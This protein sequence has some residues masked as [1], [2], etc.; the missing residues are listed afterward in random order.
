MIV[1]RRWQRLCQ[2]Y[3]PMRPRGSIWRQ[4]RKRKP[5]DLSQG[6]K[7]HV[8]ATILSACDVFEVVAPYLRQRDICFKAPKSLEELHTLNAGSYGFSQV[9]KFITVYPRSTQEA[10]ELAHELDHRTRNQ[11]APEVP[12]DKPLR[13]GSCVYYRYGS[14]ATRLTI[15]IRNRRQDAIVGKNGKVVVD[16]RKPGAAVPSWLSD[17]FDSSRKKIRLRRLSPLETTFGEYESLVQRGKGGVYRAVNLASRRLCIIK[18]GRRNGE[19]DWEGYDGYHLMEREARFLRAVSPR[20][21][22]VP[23][24]LASFTAD[25]SFHLVTKEI[26]G[27]SLGRILRGRQRLSVQ[28]TLSYC[29]QMA[30]IVAAIHDAGWAWR[31]CKPDNF[32]VRTGHELVAV[33]FETACRLNEHL[34][35]NFV[36]QGYVSPDPSGLTRDSPRAADL[37]A[38]G[39]SFMRV[40]NHAVPDDKLRRRFRREVAR[41]KFPELFAGTAEALASIDPRLR[42]SART[43][44]SRLATLISERRS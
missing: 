39:I 36:T 8:S 43:V 24:F 44:V 4:S 3:L 32:L 31:D 25:G 19:T 2:R 5:G 9:G 22:T 12:W 42:L 1:G 37:Y 26:R 23:R 29:L 14:F 6:W 33:D 18:E 15:T 20:I 17:P 41:R 34:P 38:L 11:P 27:R 30:K 35:S 13:V 40:V 21:P 10:V 7:I 28:R 16:R